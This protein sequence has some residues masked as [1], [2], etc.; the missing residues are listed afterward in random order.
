[1]S[2]IVVGSARSGVKM[3]ESVAFAAMLTISKTRLSFP[4]DDTQKALL[5]E[6]TDKDKSSTW[7]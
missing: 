3:A 4:R 2:W 7:R 1:M 5:L 6:C